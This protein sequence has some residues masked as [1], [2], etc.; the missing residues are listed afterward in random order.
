M[1]ARINFV[2]AS[3]RSLEDTRQVIAL[4]DAEAVNQHLKLGWRLI[5]KYVTQAHIE[6][7]RHEA[8]RFVLAWMVD[9]PPQIPGMDDIRPAVADPTMFDDLGDFSKLPPMNEQEFEPRRS[10]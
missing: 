10:R 3:F 5:D 2:L 1:P 6:G 9:E 4:E 7:P 8:M